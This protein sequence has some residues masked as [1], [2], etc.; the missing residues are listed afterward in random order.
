MHENVTIPLSDTHLAYNTL[1]G[2]ALNFSMPPLMLASHSTDSRNAIVTVDASW[3]PASGPVWPQT[4]FSILTSMSPG[5]LIMEARMTGN[6]ER[7]LDMFF[8]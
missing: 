7:F 3:A 5:E 6:H 1:K 4:K 2:V 8:T